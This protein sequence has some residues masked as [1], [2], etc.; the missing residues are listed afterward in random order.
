MIFRP[1]PTFALAYFSLFYLQGR[2]S[3]TCR[4]SNVTLGDNS[5]LSPCIGHTAGASGA[6]ILLGDQQIGQG[7]EHAQLR[8][9]L[10]RTTKR[11]QNHF[12]KY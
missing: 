9:V 6:K 7:D 11:L 2:I 3:T 8:E 10:L 5:A 4:F 1:R 12:I